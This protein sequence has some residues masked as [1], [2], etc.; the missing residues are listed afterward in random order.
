[1]RYL[2]ALVLILGL[3]L[4]AVV[5]A[6]DGIFAGGTTPDG[7][8]NDPNG[9]R[10]A[11]DN[12]DDGCPKAD[13]VYLDSG[14]FYL[15]PEDLTTRD[16]F[17]PGRGLNIDFARSYRANYKYNGPI[18][19]GWDF[20]LNRRLRQLDNGNLFLTT[21]TC[22][23]DV[24][25]WNGTTWGPRPGNFST[26]IQNLD[27]SFTQSFRSGLEHYFDIDGNLVEIRDRHGNNIL[28]EYSPTKLPIQGRAQY[29]VDNVSRVVALE[30]KLLKVTDPTGRE[31]N[32]TYHVS[33]GRIHTVTD[34]ISRTWTY[35]YDDFGNL[36]DVTSPGIAEYPTG[37]TTMYVYEDPINPHLITKVI[38]PTGQATGTA[39]VTNE[40]DSKG[41]VFRQVLADG[42]ETTITFDPN[43]TIVNDGNGTDWIYKVVDGQIVSRTVV[44]R[45]VRDPVDEPVGTQYTINYGYDAQK[46]RSGTIFPEGNGVLRLYDSNNPDPKA[47]G[48]LLEVRRFPKP[49]SAEPDIVTK[50]TYKTPFYQIGTVEDPRGNITEFF[51]DA[52]NNLERIQYPIV[53]EG[54]PEDLISING[55]GQLVTRTDANGNTVRFEY[56]LNGYLDKLIRAFGTP[57]AATTE[58]DPDAVGRPTV[59]RDDNGHVSALDF[60]NWNKLSKLTA[61]SPLLYEREMFYDENGNLER[62]DTQSE[63]PADPETTNFTYTLLDQL[64]TIAN[65]LGETTQFAYDFNG[66]RKEVRDPELNLTTLL[67][68][69]RDLL[70]ERT[71]AENRVTT[72]HYH[73]N[74]S[75]AEVIDGE[76]R[77]TLYDSDDFDRL[78]TIT[79]EDATTEIHAYDAASNLSTYT[80]RAGDDWVFTYDARNRRRTKVSPEQTT[81][82][83]YDIGGRMNTAINDDVAQAFGY[84]ARN[85]LTSEVWTLAG[86]SAQTVGYDYDGAD[87]QT[88]L[89]YPDSTVI[90]YEY[91][92]FNRLRFIRDGVGTALVE[93]QY[94]ELSRVTQRLR[95]SS[96]TSAYGYDRASRVDNIIH[97]AMSTTV[98]SIQLTY[99]PTGIVDTITDDLGLHDY[100]YDLTKQLTFVDEPVGAPFADITFN[101]DDAGNRL[102]TQ[103]PSTTTYVPN[104]LNQ[105]ASVGGTTY[106]YDQNGNLTD[107]G[108]NTYVFDT[109]NRFT[110]ATLDD[111]GGG[112]I[113]A[114]YTYDPF[115]RRVSKTVDG[116]TTYFVWGGDEMLAELDA[117]G[118]L[119]RRYIYGTGF[120]PNVMGIPDGVGGEDLYY[121][122]Q[123]HL[124]T[125]RALT[126]AVGNTVWHADYAPFGLADVD[127][128]A[129]VTFPFRFPGQYED[130]ESGLHYNRFRY[131]DPA[132]G[133]YISADPIGQTGSFDENVYRYVQNAPLEQIDPH[134]LGSFGAA[135]G[136]A[137]GGLIGG[138]LG[139]ATGGAGGAVLGAPS[140]PGAVIT[141]T[142]GASEGAALGAAAGAFVGAF[143]GD[144]LEDAVLSLAE[145]I[146][147]GK[148]DDDTD[149]ECEDA[150]ADE[151][152]E[153]VEDALDQL[154]DL[155]AAQEAARQGK[156]GNNDKP[157]DFVDKSRQAARNA[158]R[159]IRSTKDLK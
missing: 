66:N 96:A 47:R 33:N 82:F 48:N 117:S 159:S 148:E 6:D 123:N 4:T 24:F 155:E 49:A 80:T 41:R 121:T 112:T 81:T 50:F 135:V 129:S 105:Y 140:G 131:Y 88:Q 122:H 43:E 10:E 109:E 39:R 84:N 152:P 90:D 79:H 29:F 99:D 139:G 115:M 77:S 101:Y 35:E 143:V 21:G 67:Y 69:E 83:A 132:D 16:L 147:N 72:F 73:P 111:G 146:D 5:R 150:P 95:N 2:A 62:V 25:D 13:P 14:E 138:G 59:L 130:A 126:D 107:D 38:A 153:D 87:N 57:L 108:T 118:T 26:I 100:D 45:G 18:G 11:A 3:W 106:T 56:D 141:T 158:L 149:G 31:V 75:L 154:E 55:L 28:L 89:T 36:T 103:D 8:A 34:W 128:N 52:N 22:R 144:K 76:S 124:D 65:E 46:R 53:P 114:S 1:M 127:P 61:P 78:K 17:I 102:S 133:R 134:G 98:E 63:I 156:R 86:L 9:E 40:Y 15:D 74:R 136:A 27:G 37:T 85:Q 51:Y 60:N 137:A 20:R 30:Y 119:D 92:E 68:D 7:P 104:T 12:P 42:R 116:T 93:D 91:D 151:L 71:D 19:V 97:T 145:A 120:T 64:A 32:V 58:L 94:D 110:S 113:A 70:F 54:T 44:T 142:V 157:I 125:P 23:T